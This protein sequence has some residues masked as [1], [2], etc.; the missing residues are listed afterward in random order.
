M[1]VGAMALSLISF[2]QNK[3]LSIGNKNVGICFGNSQNYTGLRMN[4]LDRNVKRINGINII[5][6]S[7]DGSFNGISVGFSLNHDSISNGLSIGLIGLGAEKMNGIAFGTI[8][9]AVEKF[10]GLGIGGLAVA[11]D[12]LNGIFFGI[13]GNTYMNFEKNGKIN[14][15]TAGII[16]GA[17]AKKM[18]GL[19]IGVIFNSVEKHTGVMIAAFNKSKELHGIQFGLLN[20]A[21]NNKKFFRWMPFINFNFRKKPAGNKRS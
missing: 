20:Y 9:I 16:V 1:I 7:E 11:G 8:G 2:S 6:A 17:N 21:G 18:N 14:G 3:Y 5:V 10:N 19:S 13:V 15:L 12:T 4:F